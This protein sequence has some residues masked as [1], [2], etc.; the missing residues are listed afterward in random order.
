MIEDLKSFLTVR[1]EGMSLGTAARNL[2]DAD[3]VTTDQLVSA[4][5]QEIRTT[6]RGIRSTFVP[7]FLTNE[8]DADCKMCGMRRSNGGLHR[9]SATRTEVLEQL[10]ILKD[11]EGVSRVGFLTGEY[12]GAYKRQLNRAFIGWAI[13]QAFRAG[14]EEVYFNVGSFE[15]DEAE[16]LKSW[17]SNPG[18]VVMCVFQE[19][20]NQEKFNRIMGANSSGPKTDFER[21]KKSFDAWLSAGMMDVN[22][23]FLVG[24]HNPGEEIESL[25]YHVEHLKSRGAK[26]RLSLPRLRPALGYSDKPKIGDLTYLRIVAT[27]A[28]AL[29]DC[30]IV[31]TTREPDEMQKQLMPLIGIVS[32]GSPDVAPYRRGQQ[33]RNDIKSSQFV[34]PDQR[35]PAEV[36]SGLASMGYEFEGWDPTHVAIGNSS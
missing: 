4:A 36:L 33:A 8:C 21:R 11:C 25:I 9:V 19:T 6:R 31:I 12:D 10:S 27:I 22:P 5:S 15:A 34:I 32:P 23:G 29:P 24:L 35:R 16:D 14:F 2:F 1:E 7:I 20:Y 3:V 13:D 26:V 17:I 30:P 18:S 28:L